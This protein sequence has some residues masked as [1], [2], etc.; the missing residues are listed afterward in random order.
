MPGTE[1]QKIMNLTPD[2][3]GEELGAQELLTPL[4]LCP[5]MLQQGLK[6]RSHYPRPQGRE[7]QGETWARPKKAGRSQ[8][9]TEQDH[10]L[11]S[12]T[13]FLTVWV[14]TPLEV[15]WPFHRGC[16]RPSDNRDIYITIHKS[17][18]I[19]VME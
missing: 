10:S 11:V 18:K 19:I 7:Q 13:V 5:L 9:G 2:K 8:G 17:S 15:E 6:A 4:H 14:I 16:L 12:R 1:Q 3:E